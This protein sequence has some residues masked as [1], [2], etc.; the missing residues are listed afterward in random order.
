MQPA[1]EASAALPDA[2]AT[3]TAV[4]FYGW[5]IVGASLLSLTVGSASKS[6]GSH[7]YLKGWGDGYLWLLKPR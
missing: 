1:N 5:W 4:I 7:V 3:S 2:P 6:R